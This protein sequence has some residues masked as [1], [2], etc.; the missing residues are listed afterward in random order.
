MGLEKILSVAGKPGLYKLIT[1]T[2]T[3][4]VAESLLDGK[5]ITVSLRSSVSVL[6]EIAIYTLEEEVPLRDVFKKI[7]EKEDGGKT[8][9]G[10]KEEKIKLEEYFFEVLP[11]YD[12][13]RVYVSDIKKVIQW[14]NILVD[15]KITDFS[16]EEVA[17]E[18]ASE[19]E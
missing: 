4:F 1:Q 13:D 8:S 3:G 2:R 12:E 18:E 11:N 9:I 14:Y 15:N 7:Q 5:R 10:H 6:S 17:S 16:S 19:E